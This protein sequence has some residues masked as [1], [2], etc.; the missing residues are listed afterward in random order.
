MDKQA[1]R[2]YLETVLGVFEEWEG[3]GEKVRACEAPCRA[4]SLSLQ[5]LDDVQHPTSLV[6][7]H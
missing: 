6:A 1:K 4:C 5:L 7:P 3:K 2:E